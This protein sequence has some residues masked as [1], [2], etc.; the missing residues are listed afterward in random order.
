[1]SGTGDDEAM[2]A[3]PEL[4]ALTSGTEFGGDDIGGWD[5]EFISREDG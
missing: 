4:G 1:M 2:I 3:G 5:W